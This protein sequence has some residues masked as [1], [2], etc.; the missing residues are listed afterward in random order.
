[1]YDI[2]S[3]VKDEEWN[4]FLE[5]APNS[6][7]FHTPE[8]K[9]IVENTFDYKPIYMFLKDK[10]GVLRGILPL[11]YINKRLTGKRICSVPFSHICGA[12]GEDT[13]KMALYKTLF[14]KYNELS[15]DIAEI[16]QDERTF[17]FHTEH[18][19]STYVLNVDANLKSSLSKSMRRYLNKSL[20]FNDIVRAVDKSAINDIYELN[21]LN[22]KKNRVI[23]PPKKFFKNMVRYLGDNVHFHLIMNKGSSIGGAVSIDVHKNRLNYYIGC[24][25]PSYYN[26]YP[27]YSYLWDMARLCLEK[28]TKELDLGPS[29]PDPENSLTKFKIRWGGKEEKMLYSYFPDVPKYEA[30][31]SLSHKLIG[32]M[33]HP[34]YKL[35]SKY[36]F[37]STIH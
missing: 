12:L 5:K 25:D 20:A 8:W 21:C 1:M 6:N 28:G 9:R 15:A 2:V 18:K 23:A 31:A 14:L 19:F 36:V 24:T 11:F 3:K 17:G 33:P 10:E 29:S 27:S 7:I 4:E 34:M 13:Y 32:S 16:R 35:Y 37:S 22:K 26:K 30:K